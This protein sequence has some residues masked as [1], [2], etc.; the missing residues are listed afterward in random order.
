MR[1]SAA[2]ALAHHDGAIV[3]ATLRRLTSSEPVPELRH[4]AANVLRTVP[5]ATAGRLVAPV[6]A[7]LDGANYRVATPVAAAAVLRAVDARPSRDVQ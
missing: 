2:V 7:A 1:W 5:D 6:V 4:T 3:E